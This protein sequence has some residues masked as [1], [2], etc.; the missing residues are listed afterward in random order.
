MGIATR[1]QEGKPVVQNHLA[2][3]FVAM[4]YTRSQSL[5]KSVEWRVDGDDVECIGFSMPRTFAVPVL[6]APDR[7]VV[8]DKDDVR[9]VRIETPEGFVYKHADLVFDTVRQ[10]TSIKFTYMAH[11]DSNTGY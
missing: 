11:A 10:T 5:G 4:L 2:Q 7:R 3:Q 6:R 9:K 8:A 1:K